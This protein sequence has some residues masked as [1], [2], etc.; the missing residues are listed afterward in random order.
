MFFFSYTLKQFNNSVN[1]FQIELWKKKIISQISS[2]TTNGTRT[3][4]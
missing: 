2:H 3:T 1:N 4:V